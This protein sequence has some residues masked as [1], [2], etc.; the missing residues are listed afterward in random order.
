MASSSTT[1][2]QDGGDNEPIYFWREY[3]TP[4]CYMSQWYLSPFTEPAIKTHYKTAEQYMMH[5]KALLFNDPAIASQ[6]LATTSP[7]AQKSLGRK[8]KNFDQKVWEAE[9]LKIVEEGTYLKFKFGSDRGEWEGEKVGLRERLLGTSERELVEASPMDRTWGIGFTE[10]FADERREDWGL[11]LLGVALMS[12][13]ERL[14]A[15]E[16]GE[17]GRGIKEGD[18]E[19]KEKVAEAN[20]GNHKES[21][22]E[23]VGAEDKRPHKRRRNRK[24]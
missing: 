18:V 12:V 15:E 20:V 24:V 16:D 3:G 11:N 1:I 6:I 19:G 2:E 14:R 13:R 9:R 4:H 8:V 10:R 23:E 17:G 7:K 22:Q 5:R 21:E